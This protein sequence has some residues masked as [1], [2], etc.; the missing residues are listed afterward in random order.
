MSDIG[1]RHLD[2][3]RPMVLAVDDVR[4]NLTLAAAM[5][6]A[7]DVDIRLAENGPTALEF[8]RQ[9]PQPDLILLDVMMPGMDGRTVLA[10]L[11]EDPATR[12]IPVIF[13]TALDSNNDEQTGLRDGAVDY[14]T[15]PL[16]PAIFRARVRN[17]LALKLAR[18]QL[19]EQK[20]G[21]EG[22]VQRRVAENTG[23]ATRLQLTL[24]ASGLGIWELNRQTGAVS[25]SEDMCALLGMSAAPAGLAA[26]LALIHPEDQPRIGKSLLQPEKPGTDTII[27]EFRMRHA[28]GSWRWFE[29]R[30]KA[31]EL[32]PD[33]SPLRIVGTMSDISRRKSIETERQLS[34]VVFTGMND[35]ICITDPDS[36]IL[37]V[38]EAFSRVTGYSPEEAVGQTPALLKSG[39]HGKAFYAAIW[40]SLKTYDAWQGEITNRRKNGE[41]V[42]EWLSISGVRDPA[43]QITHYV[44]IF[45]DLSE[46]QAAA[47]RIQYLTSFD[48]LTDLPNR[49]LLA[50]R[51]DQALITARRY[52]RQTAVILLDIDRFRSIN[53]TLGPS[54]GDSILKEIARRL[55][56]Q[57]RDGDTIG[58][59]AGNEFGFVMANLG[60]ERDVMALA[61]RMQ[62]AVTAPLPI[63]GQNLALTASIGISLA[64]R[65]G[66]TAEAL[67]K[68]ADTAL[69]RA[70][71]AGRDTFCFYSPEMDA[72][73]A[74]RMTMEVA[75]RQSLDNNELSVVY[76]PQVSLESGKIIG[77]EAL[78]RWH[79][80]QLG[81]VSP[82]EFIPLAEETGLILPIGEWVLR[83]ACTQAR[84]WQDL[85]LSSRLR[86][87]V[88]LSARQF[89]QPELEQ[90]VARA[91]A[92]S[93]LPASEL[94]LEITET[95]F[96]DDVDQAI[97][98]CRA[99][100][101]LGIK[102]SLDD[103]GTGY[104]SLSSVSRFPFD[105]IKIDQSFVR[106]ITE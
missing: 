104:S 91:L 82:A 94:E 99:L 73:A 9:Q 29:G 54:V 42:T 66:Q 37:L 14:I 79:T 52:D 28:D 68:T 101:K 49:N 92:D 6:D 17:H 51:L 76:Q 63:L 89:R 103:F 20:A 61:Q 34:S 96:I 27:D 15:K 2:G 59:R 16:Q 98:M 65:D 64:P 90:V 44:G 60:H 47:Q 88:N 67:L 57:V 105:K 23:L 81:Q 74:R 72:D 19:S 41:L 33:G 71:A 8:A 48:P 36:R 35:G 84:R 75:L 85:G 95:A 40:E 24:S 32:A 50:D 25:W 13:V 77:M 30:G 78:L 1:M 18:D 7:L 62:Q 31:V 46:R 69:S 21:L 12:E 3:R 83:T 97:A 70:K 58:R 43:G 93:Q 56:E 5:L 4:P 102:L 100:K 55:G 53:E 87:A 26:T 39:T 80:P 86:L 22:E 106:D 38:N 10:K 45:S 11:L